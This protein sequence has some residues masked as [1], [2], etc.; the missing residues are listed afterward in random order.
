VL[1]QFSSPMLVATKRA[2]DAI[3]AGE[4]SGGAGGGGGGVSGAALGAVIKEKQRELLKRREEV[5][6]AQAR[7]R[8]IEQTE[9]AIREEEEKEERRA[10]VEE[11]VREEEKVERGFRGERWELDD[12]LRAVEAARMAERPMHFSKEQA[13]RTALLEAR[14][15]ASNVAGS[16]AEDLRRVRD[17]LQSALDA[18]GLADEEAAV[19]LGKRDGSAGS[20]TARPPAAQAPPLPPRPPTTA[21]P[22]FQRP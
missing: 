20:A 6:E 5:E 16:E 13:H 18:A 22:T 15:R 1:G 14:Q 17:V 8:F 21:R 19:D 3:A 4:M 10:G 7:R 9:R 11:G 12:V 2:V